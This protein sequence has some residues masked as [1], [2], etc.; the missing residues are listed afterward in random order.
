[1]RICSLA[2]VGLSTAAVA[3][4]ITKPDQAVLG[5]DNQDLYLVELGPGERRWIV[6]DEKWA[7]KRV[8]SCH[9][10]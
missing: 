2:V 8:C 6:E 10:P 1:M 4:S 5:N 9:P 7:L 3:L